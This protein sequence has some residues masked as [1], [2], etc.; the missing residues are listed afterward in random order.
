[1]SPSQGRISP[2]RMDRSSSPT[3]G[4]GGFVQSAMLKRSDSINKRWN[5]QAAAGLKRGD[6]IS[7]G[8]TSA[9]YKARAE[10]GRISPAKPPTESHDGNVLV[11]SYQGSTGGERDRSPESKRWSPTKSTWLESAITKTDPPK[12]KLAGPTQPSWIA[13][14][15]KARQARS[16]AEPASDAKDKSAI[17]DSPQSPRPISPQK[18]IPS[19]EASRSVQTTG[20]TSNENEPNVGLRSGIEQSTRPAAVKSKPET[21]PKKDFRASLKPRPLPTLD[22]QSTEPEFKNVFGKLKKTETKNYVAPDEFKGNI[23]RGK[24]ALN[25]T[26]GPR[27]WQKKDEFKDSILKKKQEMKQGTSVVNTGNAAEA[28]ASAVPEALAKKGNMSSQPFSGGTAPKDSVGSTQKPTSAQLLSKPESVQADST[29]SNRP[30]FA[31]SP[32]MQRPIVANDASTSQAVMP[33]LIKA[34]PAPP[35]KPDVTSKPEVKRPAARDLVATPTA[36]RPPVKESAASDVISSPVANKAQA[37]DSAALHVSSKPVASWPGPVKKEAALSVRQCFDLESRTPSSGSGSKLADRFNPALASLL[38]KGRPGDTGDPAPSSESSAEVLKR[39]APQPAA[40]IPLTHTTKSRA[41]G[42]KRRL[43]KTTTG[44]VKDENESSDSAIKESNNVKIPTLPRKVESPPLQSTSLVSPK[45]AKVTAKPPAA[46]PSP[47]LSRSPPV[48]K[49][50]PSLNEGKS[51]LALERQSLKDAS[52]ATG[53]KSNQS[54]PKVEDSSLLSKGKSSPASLSEVASTRPP[55]RGL[56]AVASPKVASPVIADRLQSKSPPTPSKKP[57]SLAQIASGGSDTMSKPMSAKSEVDSPRTISEAAQYLVEFFGQPLGTVA[58]DSF[59]VDTQAILQKPPTSDKIKSL[60]KE[61]WEI[62]GDGKK[63]PVPAQREHIL[64]DKSMFLCNHVFS[65]ANGKRTTEVYLWCGKEVSP[66]AVEDAQ[67]FGRN[68]ARDVGTKLAIL[69]QG[70]EPSSFFEALGG[71]VITR[72]GSPSSAASIRYMLSGRRHLGHVAFDETAF[73]PQNLCSGFTCLVASGDGSKLFLWKGKGSG[74]D[75]V[76]CARLI[77]MDLGATGDVI[78]VDDG[79]EP[80]T[81]WKAFGSEKPTT[82]PWNPSVNA[83]WE[84]YAARL[85][86]FDVVR[87]KSGSGFLQWARR[88]STPGLD[89]EGGTVRE[90]SPFAQSDLSKEGIFVLDTFFEIFV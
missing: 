45:R 74:T 39:Q 44:A 66:S 56:E 11:A 6:S 88:A 3:K 72:Q 51:S 83:S 71:I 41:R 38:A 32:Q 69:E 75:M 46:L 79:L 64:F 20:R 33:E 57:V 28:P 27:P 24:A 65:A 23:T 53:R 58:K 12:T 2:D 81:F 89:D 9:V 84:K 85:F 54:S 47:S 90:I 21:P 40:A 37:N 4:L 25:V 30:R 35:A 26:D 50:K 15:N 73:S 80:D 5:A 82:A 67:L 29:L 10:S 78:E 1:M 59:D 55:S 43:P 61:I 68:V 87:P 22:G 14:I 7:S 60:R 36:D 13:E 62:T 19:F 17:D 42:P 52:V 63:T 76:G 77:A 31:A 70:K 86:A 8:H 18:S 34:R 49:P 48:L 16:Q